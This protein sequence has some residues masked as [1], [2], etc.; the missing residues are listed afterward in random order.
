M[1]KALMPPTYSDLM[2]LANGYGASQTLLSANALDV[3]TVIGTGARA[4]EQIARGCHANADG[5]RLLLDALVSLG[6]LTLRGGR[7][8][9]TSLGRRYLDR[10]SPEA[11]T[12]L[13]WLL[14]HHW[15]DWG[16]LPQ[17]LRKARK[18]WARMTA[19]PKFRERFSWAM[20]ERS[21]ALA[22]RTI[23]TIRLDS[24]DRRFLDLG[25]GPGSYAIALAKRY[26]QL[27]GVIMDQ[28][29]TVAR[30]L[31]RER[32]LTRRL[33]VRAGDV[34]KDNLG[35]GYDAVLCSNVIHIFNESENLKLLRRAAHSLRA[36][37]KLFI[38]EFFLDA[39]RTAPPKSA[40]FSVMMYLYTPSGRAYSWLEVERWLK[41]LGFGRF[42]RHR[43]TPDIGTLEATKL[44]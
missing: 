13:L 34:F 17:A 11:I 39:S 31:I 23:Q 10:R 16:K 27:H 42:K 20:H 40:V 8:R 30:R 37:G 14:S 6:L 15:H 3:F 18:G 25:G 7:Y 19:T 22:E 29:V 38:V 5:L 28:T 9:N 2:Q 43:I 1:V 21:H 4:A 26:P 12:N 35:A 44:T 33:T 24:S 36:G 41:T 32:G